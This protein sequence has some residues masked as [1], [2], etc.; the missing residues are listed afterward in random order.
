[1]EGVE[2]S[3]QFTGLALV[4]GLAV[5]VP[6]AFSRFRRLRV[7]VVVGEILAGILVGRSG[8]SWVQ[9]NDATLH[10]LAEVGFVFL[11]FLAG[12][13]IDISALSIGPQGKARHPPSEPLPEKRGPSP[14]VLALEHFALTLLL[15]TG[16]AYLLWRAGMVQNLF[17]MGLVISTTSLGVV[18]P[19]L[20]EQGYLGDRYGQTL[21]VSALVADFATM[22]LITIEVAFI[23]HG[24]TL[25][26]LLIGLLFVALLTLYR[27]G[28][29]VL[30]GMRTLIEE[31]SQATTQINIRLALLTMIAFVALAQ[32]IGAE[33]ILGAFLA[34]LLIVLLLGDDNGG[35]RHQL[36]SMGYGFFIPIFFIM[37]G[38]DFNLQVLTE[39]GGS[40]LLIAVLLLAAI[41][42]KLVPAVAFRQAFGWR[43]SLGGGVLLS[44]RL[45]LIIAAAEI[46]RDLGVLSEAVVVAVILVAIVTVTAA[47]FLFTQ[48]LPRR[49]AA[50]Q[51][52]V[53]IVGA[54]AVGL[55]VASQLHEHHTPYLLLDGEAACVRRARERG[56]NAQV[57]TPET[58]EAHLEGASAVLITLGDEEQVLAWARLAR[59]ILGIERVL[60]LSPSAE[61]TRALRLLGGHPVTPL[62]AQATFLTLMA[63][64]PDLLHLLTATEDRQDLAEV[65]LRNPAL[66]GKRLRDLGLPPQV[67]VLSIHR[68]DA[69]IVPRGNTILHLGDTLTLLGNVEDLE[70]VIRD[71][72]ST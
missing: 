7:P 28:V 49:T 26:L 60:A 47:P 32:V 2:T 29:L 16:I 44:A 9:P 56:L 10:L 45:S 43:E 66:A 34:G 57:A 30:P 8:L 50:T 15:A 59:Q 71:L 65:H 3:L 35:L 17:L 58:G 70:T 62:E 69:F 67:L 21:L 42:T 14:L 38:V 11:M 24:L 6:L 51:S 52:P 36:E 53:V 13:E 64:N 22:V 55:Q 23:S 19:V 41:L 4:L 31:I 37:V 20:K 72:A 18:M 40:W 25:E 48:L 33:V 5:L 46:G 12:M 68:G 27:L 63:R 1:M 54:C 39:N 61:L